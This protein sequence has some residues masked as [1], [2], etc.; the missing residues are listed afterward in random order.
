MFYLIRIR[1]DSVK[2]NSSFNQYY[3]NVFQPNMPSSGWQE[4][5]I[6]LFKNIPFLLL[7]LKVFYCSA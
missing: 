4:W 7:N 6:K 3:I 5:N 1:A 2:H